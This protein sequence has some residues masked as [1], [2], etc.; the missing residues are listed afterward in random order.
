MRAW[1]RWAGI[2]VAVG[3]IGA[4]VPVVLRH[5]AGSVDVSEPLGRISE[6]RGVEPATPDLEGLD[7]LRLTLQPDRV[8]SPLRHGLTAELTIEPDLQRSA[9]S[10]MKRYDLP[11]AGVVLLDVKTGNALVYASHVSR[12]EP[13]DVNV[14]A[15]APAASIFK[16]VTAAALLEVPG[17]DAQT[18]QCYR[19]GQSRILADDLLDDPARDRWCASLSMAMGRSINVVFARLARRYLTPERLTEMAGAFGFGTVMPFD[20]KA[21]P[22]SIDLPDEPLEFARS[23][24]GFWHTSLSPLAAASMAQAIA[25][26]GVAY[27]PRVVRAV[28]D[29]SSSEW[30][31]PALPVTLRRAVRQE[32]ASELTKMMLQTVASGSAFKAFHNPSGSAYL[33][34]IRVAAKTGTLNRNE[35]SRLYTWFVGFAPADKPEV[36]IAALVVNTPLWRIKGPQLARDV[37]RAYFAKRGYPGV[38]P[39]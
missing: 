33:P 2:G 28:V 31:A 11:E 4:L 10:I 27:Q 13:F 17:I 36:A 20:V 32:V 38:T 39:P 21:E 34:F 15:E 35:E 37:L 6:Q 12:G 26:G 18:E 3:A 9:L 30:R 25:N 29:G 24:A 22:P 1:Q 16:L 14:R 19:G 5:G 8:T 7:L 23:A